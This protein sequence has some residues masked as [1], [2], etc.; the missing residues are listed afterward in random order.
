MPNLAHM[1]L[2]FAITLTTFFCTGCGDKKAEQAERDRQLI[3]ELQRN[4]NVQRE[5]DRDQKAAETIVRGLD[6]LTR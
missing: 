4:E 6:I 2:I 5:K 1:K 3:R